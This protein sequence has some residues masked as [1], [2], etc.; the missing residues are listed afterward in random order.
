VTEEEKAA[1]HAVVFDHL[2]L[3]AHHLL[4]QSLASLD[5]SA[6]REQ[7]ELIIGVPLVAVLVLARGAAGGLDGGLGEVGSLGA[8]VAH[9]P[10]KHRARRACR[11]WARFST[12]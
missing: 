4:D 2:L 7:L 12:W 5:L 10:S 9:V 3:Q 1:Q 11:P 8:F 6:Q